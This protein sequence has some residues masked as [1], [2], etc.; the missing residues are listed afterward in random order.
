M[1][2]PNTKPMTIEERTVKMM[3]SGADWTHIVLPVVRRGGSPNLGFMYE[4]TGGLKPCRIYF[5][6]IFQLHKSEDRSVIY[7]NAQ[8]AVDDGWRVD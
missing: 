1:G 6:N 4:A 2:K 7:P 5:G 3:E 8:A